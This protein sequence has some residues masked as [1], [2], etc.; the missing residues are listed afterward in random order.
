MQNRTAAIT[1]AAISVFAG[2]TSANLVLEALTAR[3]SKHLE[4]EAK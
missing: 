1:V 3:V 4:Q 2:K